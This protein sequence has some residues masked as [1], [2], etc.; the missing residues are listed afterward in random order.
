MSKK[1]PEKPKKEKEEDWDE[2]KI[3]SDLSTLYASTL[4]LQHTLDET[5]GLVGGLTKA[6]AC[7]L[8]LIDHTDNDLVLSASKT[9]HPH[10][11]GHLRLKVG[12]GITG[13]VAKHHKVVAL[14]QDAHQD[15]RFRGI[16]P[17]DRYEA[18]LS[19]P[20]LIKNKLVGVINVQHR[21]PH[22]HSQ[23]LINILSTIGRQVG[24]AIETARLYQETRTRAKALEALKAV[25][26][27]LNQDRYPEEIM[28]LIVNMTAQ[29][30]GSNICSIQLLDEKNQE[31]RVVASQSLDPAYRDKPPVK[32]NGSL[33][34]K[35]VQTKTP[36]TVADVRK[37]P[38]YQFRDLAI[39]QG[40]VSLLSVPMLYKDKVLGVMNT[41]TPAEHQF[42]AEEVSFVQSVA[43]Q[44]AA[45]IENTRLL[46]EKLAAQEALE[47]R[48]LIERAKGILMKQKNISE[49]DA[50]REIQRQSMDRRKSM[51][52]ISEAI[53]LAH[54]MV[55]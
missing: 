14:A 18:F 2:L 30:M 9:P 43:N 25:S 41:Y 17:E 49:P 34:G 33:S 37:E 47:A 52:E 53:I 55:Q 8:Y 20:I 12:E 44:C 46:S 29:M 39:R 21:K 35:T 1:S 38:S 3:F 6:D 5:I 10:E 26:H 19:I 42:T 11:I 36:V 31:L 54:E 24:A 48:K 32:V 45:A 15:P 27:T 22:T 13:W 28:Q 40:I 51:K 50:F 7:F 23:R 4:E 16:V